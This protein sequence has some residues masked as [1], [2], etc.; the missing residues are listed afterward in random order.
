MEHF[1]GSG[2]KCWSVGAGNQI[3][4]L[5][6]SVSARRLGVNGGE[7]GPRRFAATL[8]LPRGYGWAMSIADLAAI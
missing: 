1:S 2:R 4:S 5:Q 7:E 6:T 3:N 8:K